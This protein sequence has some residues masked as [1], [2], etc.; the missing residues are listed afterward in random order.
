MIKERINSAYN[1]AKEA[2]HGQKRK[3]SDLNY[4]T[5]CKAVAR[6]IEDLCGTED[7]IIIALLHD[8]IED[9]VIEYDELEREFGS[10][11]ADTVLELTS[12]KEQVEKIGKAHC[13][14]TKMNF[15]SEN[16]FTIKLAD[17]EHNLMFLSKD[18]DLSSK[19]AM[20]FI[21]RYYKETQTIINYIKDRRM[22]KVQSLLFHSIQLILQELDLRFNIENNGVKNSDTEVKGDINE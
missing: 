17:R 20:N 3:Y 1:M 15:M 14:G 4:F 19:Q 16:A 7:M 18:S 22:N 10:I 13:L 11:V 8:T 9:T 2:H 5:H 12:N 21:N 6:R